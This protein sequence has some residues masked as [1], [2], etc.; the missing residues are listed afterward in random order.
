MQNINFLIFSWTM[1]VLPSWLL[2]YCI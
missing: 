2:Y 1:Q